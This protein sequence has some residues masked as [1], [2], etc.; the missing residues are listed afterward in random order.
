MDRQIEVLDAISNN[1]EDL[2][3][4]LKS[5]D[6]SLK[7]DSAMDYV[8]NINQSLRKIASNTK[9]ISLGL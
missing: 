4:V 9:D 6:K 7:D 8:K 2:V 3:K 1:L 5:I